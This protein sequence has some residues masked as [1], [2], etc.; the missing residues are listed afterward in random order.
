MMAQRGLTGDHAV[1]LQ[2]SGRRTS[3][4]VLQFAAVLQPKCFCL[5]AVATRAMTV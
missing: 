4:A 2:Y 1:Q 5:Q 3:A